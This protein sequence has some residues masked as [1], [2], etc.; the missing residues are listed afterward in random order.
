MPLPSLGREAVQGPRAIL[1]CD[2]PASGKR[3]ASLLEGL[4]LPTEVRRSRDVSLQSRDLL[5]GAPGILVLLA[6]KVTEK[7]RRTVAELGQRAGVP[8]VVV[9]G[10]A[11]VPAAVGMVKA[12]AV[13]VLELPVRRER[14]RAAIQEAL[15]RQQ[16]VAEAAAKRA[17][18]ED[19]RA[20]LTPRELEVMAMLLGG[21]CSKEIAVAL[22]MSPRTVDGHRRSIL[23]RMAVGSTAELL[24]FALRSA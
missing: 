2:T 13:D 17:Q 5:E 8:T 21:K 9:A 22:D 14:L 4:G 23:R 6:D 10:R 18:F 24:G 1:V 16:R 12:G 20:S 15:A 19:R 7:L 3:V 11:T